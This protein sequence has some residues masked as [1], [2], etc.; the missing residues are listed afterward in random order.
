MTRR[1]LQAAVLAGMLSAWG[2]ALVFVGAVRGLVGSPAA[3]TSGLGNGSAPLLLI[4]G[5]AVCLLSLALWIRAVQAAPAARLRLSAPR[6][7]PRVALVLGLLML[8][9]LGTP[10]EARGDLLLFAA[11]LGLG[12]GI[13]A[14]R[15]RRWHPARLPYLREPRRRTTRP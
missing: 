11:L 12:T 13:W 8:A 15:T 6:G 3:A 7:L 14:V 5:A 2:L 1:R 4:G 10:H 9:G